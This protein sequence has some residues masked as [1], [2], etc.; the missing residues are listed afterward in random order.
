[1]PNT[2][3]DFKQFRVDQGQSGMK[4]TTEGCILGAWARFNQPKRILDIG[5]GTGL[6]SLMLAQRYPTG[7]IDAVEL[8]EKAAQ[9]AKQNFRKSP[10][11]SKLTAHHC[12]IKD[13]E[14]VNGRCYDLI[15][16][17]PPFFKNDLKSTNSQKAKAI[18]NDNL[19]QSLLFV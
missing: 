1:M 12:C 7:I 5:T 13:F 4:V 3:F 19:S 8:D 6:L 2:Y 16:C 11:S 15:I 18:H 9:Q 17:N 14:A 10:W